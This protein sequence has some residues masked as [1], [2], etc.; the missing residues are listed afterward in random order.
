MSIPSDLRYT[1]E[2]EWIRIL[3][4]GTVKIGI[5]HFAQYALGDVVY[6]EVPELGGRVEKGD[7]FGVVESVKSVSDLFGPVDGEVVE[8]NESLWDNPERINS[9][10]YTD[11]WLLR[12]KLDDAAQFETLMDAAAYTAFVE[13]QAH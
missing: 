9:T 8:R 10:P 5:T 4:D 7:T 3:D 6:V 13:A 1:K 11:G 2:H 12:L